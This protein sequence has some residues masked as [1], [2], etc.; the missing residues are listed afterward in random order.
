MAE[1][2][3]EAAH[4]I[5]MYA[6]QSL[7]IDLEEGRHI[8]QAPAKVGET[9][10]LYIG[11]A[12]KILLAHMPESKRSIILDKLDYTAY[13][14]KTITKR[15]DLERELELILDQGFCVA[16]DDY[17]LGAHAIGAPIRDYTNRVIAG[18]SL[19][20]PAVRYNKERKEEIIQLVLKSASKLTG[21]FRHR[22][23]NVL[24]R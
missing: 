5:V 16:E 20:I 12:P 6:D 1:V 23:E 8:L 18:I 3:G 22:E 19:V 24:G 2:S 15:D 21:K 9:I 10:P 17:E 7:C 4:L 14:P 11:A 13:T